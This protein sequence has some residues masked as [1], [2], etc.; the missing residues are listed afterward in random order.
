MESVD[1]LDKGMS[2][3]P[4]RTEQYSVRFHHT[5]QNSSQFKLI[6]YLFLEFPAKYFQ[7]PLTTQKTETTESET[8]SGEGGNYS[9]PERVELLA[10]ATSVATLNKKTY[11]IHLCKLT[12]SLTDCLIS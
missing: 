5:T 1:L 8:T 4:G 7:V 6:N 3:V 9:K 2:H 11:P 12:K 10:D